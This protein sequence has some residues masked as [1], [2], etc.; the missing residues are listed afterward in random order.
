MAKNRFKQ[1]TYIEANAETLIIE[2]TYICV[3]V[4]IFLLMMDKLLNYQCN[5]NHAEQLSLTTLCKIFVLRLSPFKIPCLHQDFHIMLRYTCL[6]KGKHLQPY[7]LIKLP[8]IFMSYDFQF[9]SILSTSVLFCIDLFHFK[10]FFP[11]ARP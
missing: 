9:F 10:L 3:N 11:Q 7:G 2:H 6:I 1:L 4:Y 5:S 8:L